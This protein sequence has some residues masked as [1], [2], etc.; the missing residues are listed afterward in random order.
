[1]QR[2]L[3]GVVLAC[4][5][6]VIPL[7]AQ[8][9]ITTSVVQGTVMDATGAV[10][11]GVDVTIV[12]AET[13]LALSRTTDEAGRFVFLQ[14]PPGRYTATFRLSGFGSIIQENMDLTV[15][16]ALQLSLRLPV[17]NV[18]ETVTVSGT[19]VVET[20]R[21]AVATTL[22]QRTIETTP[23]LGRKFEDLLTLTPGVSIV[24]GPDGDEITFAG[25]RGVFNNISLDG[26]DFN[27]G[28]FGEQAGGQRAPI[29]ITLDAVQEFQ[30]IASGAPAEFGRTAGGVV[31]VITKSGG[32][33]SRGS[34]F[35]FQRLEALTGQLSDGSELEDFHREQ[36]GGTLGGPIQRDRAFFFAA[37]EGIVGD[38]QR[39]GLGRPIDP[40]CPVPS[41]SLPANAALLGSSADCQRLALLDF[42]Q[43]RLGQDEGVPVNHPIKTFAM[44][45]KGDWNLGAA[46]RLAASY[47]FNHSRKQNETFD[48]A[49]YGASANGTEGDPARINVVNGNLFTTLAS[50]KLNELHFTYSRETRPRTANESNLDADTG[51]GFA[52]SFRFGDPFFIQPNVDEMIW[53][54]QIKNNLSIVS[55]SHTVKV[56]GE[57]MHTLN[58]QVFRGFFTGRYLFD[59]V[60]GFL[61]YTAPAAAGGFGPYAAGCSNGSY[62]TLPASC[63]AGTAPT[64]GPLLFYL[65]GAG[66]TGLATDATGAS[67]VANEELS[68]FIQDQWQIRSNVSLQYGLRWDAQLMPETVDPQTTAFAQFLTDPRFPSDGTIPDQ[69]GMWQPRAGATWD[70][71]G[72]GR[73][74]LRGSA[75]VYFAR[76]NMLSQVGSVTT[77]GLQQQSIFVSTDNVRQFGAVP[78]AW[79]NVIVPAAL[80]AGQFPLFTGVRVFH[81]GYEN[82]RTYTFNAGYEQEMLP[83]LSSYADL[84]YAR[85]RHLTRFINYNRPDAG[86]P[87]APFL[88]ETMVTTS[89]GKSDYIGLTLGLRKRFSNG[90]QLEANYV[91]ARD[92]DDDSN[93][94]DPFTDRVFN[95]NDL[96]LDYALS[97]RDIRHKFNFYGY[98]EVAG[99]FQFNARAQARGAQPIT[100]NPRVAGGVDQGR[101][102]LRKD[103]EYF[104]LDWRLSRPFSLS[105]GVELT[106]TVEMFNTFNNA[107][108]INPLS[109][110]A[111]FNFDGFLRTGVGDPRQMQLALKL[112]F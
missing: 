75:G 82:P 112:T 43:T 83:D 33:E 49:T 80:P 103:N 99:G 79:P 37:L 46:S 17:G 74:V 27:N 58:D 14:L 38:F 9:Q 93:E 34:V 3:P 15:G 4:L 41:P 60:E 42:F 54:T 52:P 76:Q 100:P 89:L 19:P 73:S 1:M 50:N 102:T 20:T 90:Y 45:L 105:E 81:R 25:Q 92:K 28:F 101:N 55:G 94:R 95:F 39:P 62:V 63:P 87:F 109:T 86:S 35:Y 61:R 64:G 22:N 65:Q 106:P 24:Q 56:G 13:N 40:P 6:G 107:N 30:V 32:N 98:F 97:D 21:S 11:P 57:W 111:L 84:T 36:F 7:T 78:P 18:T 16:Q 108:N 67:T 69:R 88:D 104:S 2:M 47:N 110:P 5:A 66:R 31:N 72:N 26:G 68:L 53:R 51:I 71:R 59:S 12:S 91:V 29:D 8:T 96:S 77:N 48:V 10:L 23:I 44:L 70:V 85:A